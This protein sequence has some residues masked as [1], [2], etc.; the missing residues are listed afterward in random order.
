MKPS[1]G[2]IV[3][4]IREGLYDGLEDP[5]PA[6]VTMVVEDDLIHATVFSPI[7]RPE[8]T[9]P[10]ELERDDCRQTVFWRWPPRV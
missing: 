7:K 9:G 1:V 3:H 5:A 4:V 2:R 6:I 8:N 10:I